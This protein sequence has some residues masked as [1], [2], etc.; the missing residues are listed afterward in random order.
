MNWTFLRLKTSDGMGYVF[1]EEGRGILHVGHSTL[2]EAANVAI[3]NL[4]ASAPALDARLRE[5]VALMRSDIANGTIPG[6][7]ARL[8][9]LDQCDKL[10]GLSPATGDAP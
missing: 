9:L 3:G 1:D 7:I 10:L 2:S 8:A 6:S 5:V 4:A